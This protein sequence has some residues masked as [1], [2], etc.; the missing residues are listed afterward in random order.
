MPIILRTP[1]KK[2]K[3]SKEDLSYLS[4]YLDKCKTDA[5]IGINHYKHQREREELYNF[6]LLTL[7]EKS[8]NKLF[9]SY[10]HLPSKMQRKRH[11]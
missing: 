8:P 4:A 10:H 1:D 6:S 9:N 3:L 7:C 5:F 2:V 11:C